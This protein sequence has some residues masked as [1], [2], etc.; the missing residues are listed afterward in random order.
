MTL[1][2]ALLGD[3]VAHSI[4]PGIHR[5]AF[6]EWGLEAEYEVRRVTPEGLE[7]A[8]RDPELCGGN[9]TLPHKLRAARLVRTSSPDVEAT[10]ACNCW[11][12]V[13]DGSM[14]GDNTD[15][16]GLGRALV[17]FEFGVEGRRVLILGA[18]GAARAAIRS[19][20]LGGVDSIAILNRT[21]TRG[22]ELVRAVSE[23]SVTALPSGVPRGRFDLVIN[24]TRLGLDPTD[25]LP[26]DLRDADVGAV[27]DMVYAA[28]QTRWV[29]HAKD[30]GIRAR[31]GLGM[32][33]HQAALSLQRWTP[34]REPPL[35]IMREAAERELRLI[36]G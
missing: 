14:A 1:R 20:L 24:A 4:S 12:R 11:W 35:R 8:M 21:T 18:G 30:Q 15:V 16:G 32:L 13:D 3:P 19:L 29:L 34:G 10:G 28:G 5:A 7:S 36:A 2:F 26:L 6:D 27:Y 33:V 23:A 9:V 25:P 31:D 17:D 22:Q